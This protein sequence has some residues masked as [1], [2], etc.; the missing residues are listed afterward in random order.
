MRVPVLEVRLA[1]AFGPALLVTHAPPDIDTDHSKAVAVYRLPTERQCKNTTHFQLHVSVYAASYA[2]FFRGLRSAPR[3]REKE[4]FAD[5]GS[6]MR[7]RSA[8]YISCAAVEFIATSIFAWPTIGTE[9]AAAVPDLSGLWAR[10]FLGF[11][12]PESGPGPI[13]NTSRLPNGQS[14]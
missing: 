13:A 8:T 9:S 2:M 3:K 6:T 14:R 10:E 11:D 12:Q 7:V 4:Q 1:A 5:G